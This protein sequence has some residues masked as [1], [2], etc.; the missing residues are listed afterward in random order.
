MGGFCICSAREHKIDGQIFILYDFRGC[1]RLQCCFK[2]V[3]SAAHGKAVG[4]NNCCIGFAVCGEVFNPLDEFFI[5]EFAAA[6]TNAQNPVKIFINIVPFQFY[7]PVI[8]AHSVEFNAVNSLLNKRGEDFFEIFFFRNIGDSA[9]GADFGAFSAAYAA[10]F[11]NFSVFN[12]VLRT[13]SIA[14]IARNTFIIINYG[15]VNMRITF[16]S[17][18]YAKISIINAG[19]FQTAF[20]R[21]NNFFICGQVKKFAA[22]FCIEHDKFFNFRRIFISCT[23]D[24]FE[25]LFC[26]QKIFQHYFTI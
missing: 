25:T 26:F 20:C 16:N 19:R 23:A 5:A 10:E 18:A 9:F 15:F 4:L 6:C 17:D 14:R 1:D 8:Q 21:I 11:F 7:F 22:G 13:D 3:F 2:I 24:E 12:C